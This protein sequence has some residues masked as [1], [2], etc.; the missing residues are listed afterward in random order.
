MQSEQD[1]GYLPTL[2][3]AGSSDRSD[4]P[5]VQTENVGML[6]QFT[7]RMYSHNNSSKVLIQI[8]FHII[9]AELIIP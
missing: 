5:L 4:H 6:E 2:V 8:S 1:L 3:S 9:H 7:T